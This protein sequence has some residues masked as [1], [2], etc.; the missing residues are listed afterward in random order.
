MTSAAV[1]AAASFEGFIDDYPADLPV[2]VIDDEVDVRSVIGRCLRRLNLKVVESDTLGHARNRFDSG[3]NFSMVFLDR[4]LPDGDGVTFSTEILSERP[5]LPVVIVTGKGS[6]ANAEQALAGGAFAYLPKPCRISEI[7]DVVFR[8]YPT[9]SDSFGQG[10]GAGPVID[11]SLGAHEVLVAHSPQMIRIALELRKLAKQTGS[12]LVTGPSGTGKEVIARKIHE[13]SE[14]AKEAFVPVNCGAIPHELI[15]S[16][17]FGHEKGSFTGASSDRK[18]FF[19]VAQG[20]TI[21][22]DEVTET[23]T[24]FQVK[25]L[26]VLQEH[27]IT[28]VGSSQE[29]ELDVRVIASSNRD[30]AAEVAGARFREDL[31]YRLNRSMIALPALKDR[32]EDIEPLAIYFAHR[33]VMK[34][35]RPV[36]FSKGVIKA[37]GS[38][39]WPGN[40]RELNSVI[41]S[42]VQGCNQMVLIS[43]LPNTLRIDLKA[44]EAAVVGGSVPLLTLR[45]AGDE[46]CLEVLRRC[47]GNR[48]RAAEILD[49][50]RSTINE[51]VKKKGWSRRFGGNSKKTH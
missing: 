7:R 32:P 10:E 13:L 49:V 14:R 4:C 29:I 11:G 26:R 40:V 24:A 36:V 48:T 44:D 27:R 38:Y 23:S 3:E 51:L 15:E 41:D 39:G 22:L 19:E 20:G 31:Y 47:G 1:G 43:D 25:L 6:F 42:A 37:L 17:L 46:Y 35:G 30:L 45:E 16:S 12:V 28:R 8:R 18:G 34:T 50:H 33:T 2:L 21:F 5:T 9:L